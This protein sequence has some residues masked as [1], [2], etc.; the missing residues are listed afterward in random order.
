M[1]GGSCAKGDITCWLANQ[2]DI[3]TNIANSLV[4]VEKLMIVMMYIMGLAFVLKAIYTL[5]SYGEART[6]SASN[7][8]IKEPIIYLIVAAAFV[9]FPTVF[10]LFMNSTFGYQSPL[11]YAPINSQ[12]NSINSLFGDGSAVGEPLTKMIQVI[13]LAAF[14]RGWIL[15]ARSSGQGQQ[16]GGVGKGLMHVFGGVMA[17]NIVGTLQI[18][19]NTLYG[20]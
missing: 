19:N 14:I 16:P 18:I 11:A 8:S 3:L 5:K 13:G 2:V 9:Y 15:I 12:N 4:P 10:E 7:A 17:I 20:T 1:A 6:M